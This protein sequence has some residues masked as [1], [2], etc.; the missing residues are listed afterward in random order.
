ML[1]IVYFVDS[2]PLRNFFYNLKTIFEYQHNLMSETFSFEE[3][4][5]SF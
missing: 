5:Y 1:H 4:L 3:V 2:S